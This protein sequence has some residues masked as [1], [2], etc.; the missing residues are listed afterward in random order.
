MTIQNDTTIPYG[1]CH[2]GCG[3]KTPISRVTRN[4][5]G[6]RKGEPIKYING[7]HTRRD[8]VKGFWSRVDIA[9]DDEC[10]EWIGSLNLNGYGHANHSMIWGA[11]AMS[12]RVAYELTKGKIPDG[13]CVLH[14][15]DNRKCVNPSHLFLGTHADNTHD[16]DKKGRR[17]DT[18]SRGEK[19]VNHKLTSN[20]VRFIRSQ[21]GKMTLSE[22]AYQYG[23]TTQNIGHIL[24][25]RSWKHIT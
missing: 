6:Y 9:S 1:Y 14:K 4:T 19:N 16:M 24:S 22:L 13:L 25:M 5:R 10:W 21:V 3:Q 11:N 8:S 2:C 12:H 20:Q 18:A 7:H 17:G 15:C 23:V